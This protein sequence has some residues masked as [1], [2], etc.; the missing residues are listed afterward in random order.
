MS[1]ELNVPAEVWTQEG[2]NGGASGGLVPALAQA[3]GVVGVVAVREVPSLA[4]FAVYIPNVALDFVGQLVG[5]SPQRRRL[6]ITTAVDIR[7]STDRGTLSAS[8]AGFLIKANLGPVEIRTADDVFFRV[9]AA[10]PG[11]VT[12]W[13]EVDPG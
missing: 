11:D 9:V 4:G 2:P 5:G 1:D 7:I 6:L 13:V 10:G 12:A 3:V 8:G